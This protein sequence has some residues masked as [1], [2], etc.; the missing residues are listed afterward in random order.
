MK[1]M[2]NAELAAGLLQ[3]RNAVFGRVVVRG[4][5]REVDFGS[6]SIM[7]KLEGKDYEPPLDVDNLNKYAL[8]ELDE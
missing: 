5:L 7:F 6:V 2:D 1:I 4:T 3:G 8:V